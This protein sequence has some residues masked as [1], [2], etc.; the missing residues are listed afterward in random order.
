V[1]RGGIAQDS[2]AAPP[3]SAGLTLWAFAAFVTG[4]KQGDGM[5]DIDFVRAQFPAFDV[6]ALKDQAFF[7][8]AGGAYPMPA[9]R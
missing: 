2:R 5:L 7:E 3:R 4:G 8:N 9:S 6:D 1:A